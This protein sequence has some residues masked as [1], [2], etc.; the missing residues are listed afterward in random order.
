MA[1]R[2]RRTHPWR[3]SDGQ[4]DEIEW[5]IAAG[6]TQEEVAATIGCDPRTV[7]RWIT[8]TGGIRTYE[9]RRSSRFLSL[10]EREEIALAIGRGEPA[11][12]IARRLGRATST[13]TREL[14]RNGG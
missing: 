9:R 2:K 12:V 4:R 14:A 8:R 1:G 7:I 3:L 5:R 11:V 10:A 6:E 13:V